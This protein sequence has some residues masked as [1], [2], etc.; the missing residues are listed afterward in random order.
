[1]TFPYCAE[2]S[3]RRI[4]CVLVA[5]GSQLGDFVAFVPPHSARAQPSDPLLSATPPN[6][7]AGQHATGC[8]RVSAAATNQAIPALRCNRFDYSPQSPSAILVVAAS[9]NTRT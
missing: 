8:H 2:G 5:A 3:P 6:P 9:A 4:E 1:M 7:V